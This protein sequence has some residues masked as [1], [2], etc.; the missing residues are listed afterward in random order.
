M[1]KSRT[2]RGPPR[3]AKKYPRL[4]VAVVTSDHMSPEDV[5]VSEGSKVPDGVKLFI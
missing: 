3:A 1:V 4:A 5:L 2:G